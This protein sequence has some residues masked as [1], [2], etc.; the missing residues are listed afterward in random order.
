MGAKP[1]FIDFSNMSGGKNNAFPP[2]AIAKNQLVD[3]IN[4]IHEKIGCTRAPGY[5]GISAAALFS[6]PIRGEFAYKH[7]NGTET[8]IVVS[9]R[10]VYSIDLT[11]GTKTQIGTLTGD[12]ECYAVN[13]IGK[14]WIV[15]GTD[16]VKVEDDLSVYTVGLPTPIGT[17]AVAKAGGT[18]ANGIYGCYCGYAR[19]TAGGLYL[20]GLPFSLGAVTLGAGNNTITFTI[21]DSTDPQVT[22]KIAWMTEAGGSVHYYFG[23]ATNAT[24]AFDVTS[25]ANELT[26]VRMD[27]EA[28]TNI[29]LP[30]APA[31]IF[32]FNDRLHVWGA[33]GQTV[34]LSMIADINPFSFERFPAGNFR[35]LANTIS[36]IFNV[37]EDL[38]I[39]TVGLGLTK[40]PY[41]DMTA[42]T[43][44]S[45]QNNWFRPCKTPMGKSY[46]E[47][48]KSVVW[49][50]TNDGIRHFDGSTFSDDL[51]FNI[52]PD[53]EKAVIGSNSSFIPS[54]IV[55]RRQGKRTE[56]RFSF[57]DTQV[58]SIINNTQ[59]V[60]NLDF[61]TTYDETGSPV[62]SEMFFMLRNQ[63]PRAG[64][65]LESPGYRT[66]QITTGL[67]FFNQ[68]KNPNEYT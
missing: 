24:A 41:G 23:E 37:G 49:G 5:F 2:H 13:A 56:L 50:W 57:R 48:Y 7:Y 45:Q 22:H 4:L 46:V 62:K 67:G 17:S 68:P 39:N 18:L 35:T 26:S 21:P 33:N 58:S 38:F 29:A 44:R 15:N 36:S 32:Y 16:F 65:L 59:L 1:E 66:R 31:G 53:I 60:F 52:K 42:V 19:K 40:I 51:S 34:Y 20:Y 43:K 11:A 6:A 12:G 28:A 64:L 55:Y 30:V 47:F 61:Y 14:L 54:M 10:K 3:S 8:L 9:D 27:I 63:S 25:D